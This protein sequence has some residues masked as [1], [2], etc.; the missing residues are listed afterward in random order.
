MSASPARRIA[1]EVVTRT[2]ERD[3]FAHE[4]LNEALGRHDLSAQDSSF[5]TRLAY[6]TI[7]TQG[8]LAE[9]LARYTNTKRLE[10]RVLDALTV[11]AYELLFL[12]TPQRAAVHEG[13]EL[14]RSL[15]PQASGLANAVLRRLAE[16]A[17]SFPWG[18]PETDTDALAR[19]YGHPRWLV[20]LWLGELG[21]ETTR[22]I[23]AADNDP[24]P[25]YLAA[26]PFKASP[27]SAFASLEESGAE[28]SWCALPGCILAENPSAAVRG[29]ALAEG[30]VIVADAS[31]QLACA[32][33]PM[34][35]KAHVV[36]IGAGR[37]TKTILLQASALRRTGEPARLTAVDLHAFK[38]S[39]LSRRMRELAV[40]SVEVVIA[41]ATR[42]S[43]LA[44][45]LP[46]MSADA[47]L[48]DAPCSGLG[49]L[50][51]HPDKRWRLRPDDLETLALLGGRMLA[52]ASSLVRPGG[53]VVYSTCTIS[54]SENADV[55]RAFLSSEAGR[56]FRVDSVAEDVPALWG[57]F[58]TSE[59]F[60]Q[61][62]PEQGGPDGHFVVRFVRVSEE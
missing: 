25:L 51:R 22:A 50:R 36:E 46:P 9:A 49:T 12:Q 5:A 19:L 6:G 4:T 62:V 60:Y 7:Q 31:A 40:P 14:V 13:V 18:D 17:P 21:Q 38:A 11:T 16:D 42:L 28:P 35:P 37:G 10:S 39:L 61:S 52:E 32:L 55:A 47:V 1:R 15:R 2:R 34:E 23:L 43:E 20:E 33:V 26:N 58:I 59:G 56:A 54:H 44:E 8:T 3:A 53:F 24:A 57:K 41:D 30:A 45:T 48:I 29:S 27:E